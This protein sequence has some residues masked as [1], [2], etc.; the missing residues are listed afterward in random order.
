[1]DVNLEPGK[2]DNPLSGPRVA[3]QG[4]HCAIGVAGY[5]FHSG[6]AHLPD[7]ERLR[8]AG[9]G[10]YAPDVDDAIIGISLR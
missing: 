5:N 9:N 2:I 8:Q 10:P 1:M 3:Q 7:I 6:S 4:C